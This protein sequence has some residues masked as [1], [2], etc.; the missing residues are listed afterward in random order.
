L[1]T[2]ASRVPS[3]DQRGEAS[4]LP[5]VNCRGGAEPSVVAS[6]IA[7]RYSFASRSIDQTT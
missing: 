2:N 6:Q 5:V 4:F 7:C 3:G 1:A